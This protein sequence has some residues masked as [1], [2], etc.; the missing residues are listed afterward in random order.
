MAH[1]NVLMCS[2]RDKKSNP[3]PVILISSNSDTNSVTIKKKKG[4]FEYEK[5]KPSM[6]HDY[7][8]YM[9]GVDEC[10]KM[11]YVY[12]DERR[13]LEYWKK[14]SYILYVSNTTEKKMNRLKFTSKIIDDIEK[15]WMY[16][17]NSVSTQPSSSTNKFALEKL[18]GRNLRQC[19]VCSNKR[20]GIK[21]SHLICAC[22][23][24]GLH[25]ICAAKHSCN[26]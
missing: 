12:L 23:K 9:G 14:V 4:N 7:N 3:N 10:D 6:I 19:A 11:L 18:P 17:K 21:R 20:S 26:T 1:E 5:M 22:C 13:T 16:H 24:K 25:A 15:E 8:K 2:F